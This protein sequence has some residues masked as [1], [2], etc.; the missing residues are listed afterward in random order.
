MEK[1]RRT[2]DSNDIVMIDEIIGEVKRQGKS[3]N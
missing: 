1:K 2:K 3:V